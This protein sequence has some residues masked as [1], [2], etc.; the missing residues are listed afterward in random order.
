MRILVSKQY[1]ISF[2]LNSLIWIACVLYVVLSFG[3]ILAQHPEKIPSG[4]S[5]EIITWNHVKKGQK[6]TIILDPCK[7]VV[8]LSESGTLLSSCLQLQ[9]N[10]HC[11]NL[12][13]VL[14]TFEGRAFPP[15]GPWSKLLNYCATPK[16]PAWWI[17]LSQNTDTSGVRSCSVEY[18][19]LSKLTQH[20]HS[21]SQRYK[22][23][24]T[25]ANKI[26]ALLYSRVLIWHVLTD[27]AFFICHSTNL[28]WPLDQDGNRTAMCNTIKQECLAGSSE[29]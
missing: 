25:T 22:R 9:L 16:V 8:I 27:V 11:R 24:H 28:G 13:Q 10:I 3:L 12:L 15:Q 5:C 7:T 17:V 23:K 21:L 14:G 1:C 26:K 19:W 18:F 6:L 2:E 4:I 29:C 20:F